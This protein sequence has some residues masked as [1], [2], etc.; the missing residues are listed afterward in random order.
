MIRPTPD[1]AARCSLSLAICALLSLPIVAQAAPDAAPAPSAALALERTPI[2]SGEADGGTPYGTWATGARYKVAF[3]DGATVVPYLGRTY[4]T[5]QTWCWHTVSARVG[6]LELR[7]RPQPARTLQEYRAEYDHGAIV[8]AYDVL[9][10]GLEQTFVLAARPPVTGDLVI[11]GRTAG[12]LRAASRG[13]EHAPIVFRDAAGAAILSYGSATAIDATGKTHAMTTA[14]DGEHVVLRLDGA[15]LAD[16]S[17]PVVV[18]PLI[19]VF[20]QTSGF[21]LIGDIDVMH[22]EGGNGRNV[23]FVEQRWASAAD[24]DLWLRRFDNDGNNSLLCFADVTTSWSSMTPSLGK[25]QR[26][27]YALLAFARHLSNDL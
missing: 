23:W 3:D 19:G 4:P 14:V 12:E 21:D 22:M 6:S 8:E 7:S 24:G 5:N 18:D 20:Y 10:A 16:A 11:T 26:G 9:A 2:H 13:P 1:V 27:G 25:H 17:Y 15:W